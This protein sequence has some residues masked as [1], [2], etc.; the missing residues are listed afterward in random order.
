MEPLILEALLER[1]D[2]VQVAVEKGE[3]WTTVA[4]WLR[5]YLERK[6]P[7]HSQSKK[8]PLAETIRTRLPRLY[9]GELGKR[10]VL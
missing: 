4:D 2:A 8:L 5:K 1:W 9:Q 10:A 3:S 6:Y 7:E